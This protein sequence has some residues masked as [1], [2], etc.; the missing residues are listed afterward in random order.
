MQYKILI[1]LL[2]GNAVA[3]SVCLLLNIHSVVVS[4]VAG[5]LLTPGG[6]LASVLFSASE[7]IPPLAVL[8]GNAVVYSAAA[9]IALVVLPNSLGVA[10]MRHVATWLVAPTLL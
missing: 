9:L 4:V 5:V 2:F 10:A 8:A 1:A 7:V 3:S 6:V